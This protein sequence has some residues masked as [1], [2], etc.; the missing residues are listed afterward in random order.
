MTSWMDHTL[1]PAEGG[2]W[3]ASGAI[4][5]PAHPN[6]PVRVAPEVREALKYHRPIVALESAVIT[7]GLPAPHNLQVAL[8]MEAEVRAAGAI[9]AT[10][11]LWEGR[12]VV[13]L[14]PAQ[15]EV[16]AQMAHDA[17]TRH[18]PLAA[19]QDFR[20]VKISVRDF[21]PLLASRDARLFGGTTVAASL[22]VAHGVGIRFF[23]TGGIGGVHY[24]PPYDIS[25]DL[26]QLARTPVLTV[27]AGAK[28]I[29]N[30]DA[31]LEYLE[32]WGVPVVGYGTDMFPAFYSVDSPWK[33]RHRVDTPSE[34]AR[35]LQTH[36]RLQMP[37]AVLLAVPPPADAALPYKYIH[38][39][40][41]MALEE[42]R[43]HNEQAAQGRGQPI[44]GAAVTPW[45]L[46]R[47][48]EL[49][50]R[51]TM[52]VNLALLRNN[53][54]VAGQVARAWVNWLAEESRRAGP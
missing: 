29:L 24:D 26:P 34:A 35:L 27:A 42:L 18:R 46:Q 33:V 6:A 25:A 53:A 20:L 31:T 36:W 5:G 39:L 21:A 1:Q 40:I 8:D 7:H 32:T 37:S 41:E 43:A 15:I 12:M 3:F 47:L 51:R 19:R 14:S 9:P 30:L 45:L 54:R 22:A 44:R 50:D 16:L 28:A 23:A 17:R 4:E 49:S 10:I 11:G 38:R 52:R 2:P 13:G 48:T